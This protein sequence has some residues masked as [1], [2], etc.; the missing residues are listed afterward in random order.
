MPAIASKVRTDAP[1]TI[2]DQMS[3]VAFNKLCIFLVDYAALP[4]LV[5]GDPLIASLWDEMLS[6]LTY[7]IRRFFT[8]VVS[9]CFLILRKSPIFFLNMSVCL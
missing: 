3:P 9:G 4:L 8:N 5:A 2:S 7:P 1:V 6:Y